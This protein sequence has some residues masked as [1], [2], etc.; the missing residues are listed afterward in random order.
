MLWVFTYSLPIFLLTSF[1]KGNF[2]EKIKAQEE[3]IPQ[4]LNQELQNR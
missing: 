1:F 2:I 4:N 3:N